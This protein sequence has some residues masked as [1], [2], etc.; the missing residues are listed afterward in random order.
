VWC[1]WLVV[2]A[3]YQPESEKSMRAFPVRL[4][5]GQRYWT[6]LDE[7]LQVVGVADG[8]LRGTVALV[9]GRAWSMAPVGCSD[10]EREFGEG[11]WESVVWV[12][13]DGQLIVSAAQVLD[14]RMSCTDHSR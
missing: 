12:E 8:F 6:V 9:E 14:K 1:S 11:C 7:D 3:D 13:I 2:V 10:G 4:P 5:S